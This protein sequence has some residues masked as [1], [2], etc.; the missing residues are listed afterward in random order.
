MK[1]TS[2]RGP[3]VRRIFIKLLLFITLFITVERLCHKQTHG[4]RLNKIHSDLA[5]S[6]D[7][8]SMP[9]SEDEIAEVRAI[10][11]QPFYFLNSGGESY[12]FTSKDGKYV[13]K[14]FKHHHMR[15]RTWMDPILPK[16]ILNKREMR[17]NRFFTSCKL[18]YEHFR[19]ETGLVF[20]HLNKTDDLNI[21]LRIFDPIGIAHL[22]N[23]DQLEF[24]IQKKVSMADP[25]LCALAEMQELDATVARLNALVDLIV[26]RCQV[27]LADHDA[28]LRNFGFI[29]EEAVEIDLGAFSFDESLKHPQAAKRALL[30]D[31]K[32]L[33]KWVKNNHPELTLFLDKKIKEE[34]NLSENDI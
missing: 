22:V 1:N 4:F 13:L 6:P 3:S 30:S 19:K 34:L 5:Y 28:Q 17:F 11:S 12:A 15:I 9:A 21:H 27:G 2:T 8:A 18:A 32:M 33:R 20:I 10:L 29:G 16:S 31:T 26:H 25:T 14:F 23:L 7:R 24:A